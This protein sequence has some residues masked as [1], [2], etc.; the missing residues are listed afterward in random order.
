MF[1]P[2]IWCGMAWFDINWTKLILAVMSFLL[3]L[4]SKLKSTLFFSY[5]VRYTPKS[6]SLEP[7]SLYCVR[8]YDFTLHCFSK[9]CLI[10]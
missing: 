7:I 10:D 5:S 4:S 2:M 3:L 1:S 9:K 6:Y 8:Y